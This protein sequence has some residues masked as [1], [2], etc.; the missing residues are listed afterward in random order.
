MLQRP[1]TFLSFSGLQQ[2]SKHFEPTGPP[3]W[4]MIGISQQLQ[5][6]LP[7]AGLLAGTYGGTQHHSIPRCFMKP[8]HA[9]G[10]DIEESG[11]LKPENESKWDIATPKLWRKAASPSKIMVNIGE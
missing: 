8:W 5:S 1:I 3:D 10:S 2:T 9:E 6:L 7:V 11:R 4:S